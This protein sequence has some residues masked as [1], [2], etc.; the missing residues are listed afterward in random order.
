[1][2][3]TPLNNKISVHHEA[4]QRRIKEIICPRLKSE[5][6]CVDVVGGVFH[7][8]GNSVASDHDFLLGALLLQLGFNHAF[9]PITLANAYGLFSNVGKTSV[10]KFYPG[11]RKAKITRDEGNDK[12]KEM[13]LLDISWFV[14][15]L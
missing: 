14:W 9:R 13:L 12:V 5:I 8:F 3:I 15:R 6:K 7:K 10:R 2:D 11:G 4:T 1:M